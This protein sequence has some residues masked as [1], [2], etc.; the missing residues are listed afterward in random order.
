M[1]MWQD[2]EDYLFDYH[3]DGSEFSNREYADATGIDNLEA[4]A[5]IQSYLSAQRSPKGNTLYVLHRREG[6]RTSN[7]RWLV[8][9]KKFNAN[10][11][12]RAYASDVVCQFVRAV[13]KDL[14]RMG[15][16]NPRVRRYVSGQIRSIMDGALVVL[17]AAVEG[18][19]E[20]PEAA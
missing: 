7:S 10:M 3:E 12:G 13:E 4:S 2:L 17:Q 1:A 20:P 16:V 9:E 5:H 15:S 19:Y 18:G 6:T 14:A 11:V 8:G